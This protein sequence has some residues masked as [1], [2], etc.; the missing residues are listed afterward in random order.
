MHPRAAAS[1]GAAILKNIL[2]TTTIKIL[3][4]G[5]IYIMNGNSRLIVLFADPLYVVE[6][7]AVP[8]MFKEKVIALSR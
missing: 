2:P 1:V 5:S 3:D 4:S 8:F 6:I 7:I